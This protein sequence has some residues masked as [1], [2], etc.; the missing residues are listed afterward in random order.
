MILVLVSE[1]NRCEGME[2]KKTVAPRRLVPLIVTTCPPPVSP[3]FGLTPVTVGKGASV[4][5]N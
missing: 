4:Y 2:P 3:V 1:R 5:V